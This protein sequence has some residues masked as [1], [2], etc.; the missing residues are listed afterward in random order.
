MKL[1]VFLTAALLTLFSAA[2]QP[3]E[4]L[5]IVATTTQAADLVTILSGDLIGET[6]EVTALMG[7]GVDPHL[8]RPTESDIA[9]MNRADAII[10]SGLHLEGQFD[11]VFN[12]LAERGVRIYAMSDPVKAAGFTF[13]GF[14]L[15]EELVDVDDPHFWFDPRNWQ[16]TAE[17]AADFLSELLPEHA[18][19][20]AANYEA[21]YEQLDLLYAWG[22]EAM[23]V[24]PEE[25]RVLVTSHDAFQYFGDAFG[26]EVRGLQGISTEDEAGVADIQDIADFVVEREI[27][28]MFVESSVPPDAIEAVREAVRDGGGQVDIGLKELYSDAMGAPE[29]F[30]GTYIGMIAQNVAIVVRSFG[31]ELPEWPEGLEPVLAESLITL[32]EE[33]Q[34]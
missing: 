10:Y 31:Y 19:T 6:I 8:Y 15:S 29:D 1:V 28:M 21:Y 12:A 11:T 7:A 2:A 13:G 24:V 17:G 9:A 32:G 20:F 3:Q 27:P 30:G 16:L 22:T 5:R 34:P 25:Q 4:P 23:S 14:T 33:V 26:W 18:E